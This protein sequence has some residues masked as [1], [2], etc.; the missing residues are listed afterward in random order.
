L[1]GGKKLREKV[2]PAC[3]AIIRINVKFCNFCGAE[4]PEIKQNLEP[5]EVMEEKVDKRQ[6]LEMD[7]SL[8]EAEIEEIKEEIKELI[9]LEKNKE[10]A[11]KYQYLANLAFELGRDKDAEG[12]IK[13]AKYF[14]D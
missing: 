12:Y 1:I 7:M 2:C 11:D 9:M 4:Q 10:V 5:H 13:K 3:G 6:N 14:L 8:I